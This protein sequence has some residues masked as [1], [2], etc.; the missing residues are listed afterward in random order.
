VGEPVSVWALPED[1]RSRLPEFRISVLVYA[2][3][4]ADRF[5]LV[6]GKRLGEGDGLA[7]G[8]ELVEI[9]RDGAVFTF[10]RYRFLV[11]R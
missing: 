5:A 9:R 3:R 6:N 8:L 7:P 11:G 2:A 4:P 1:V 10:E